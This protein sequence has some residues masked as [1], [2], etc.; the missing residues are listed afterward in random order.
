MRKKT[1]KVDIIIIAV[2]ILL[3]A[4][5]ILLALLP[6]STQ[7]GNGDTTVYGEVTLSDFN[8]KQA[9]MITGSVHEQIIGRLLPDSEISVFNNT[10][11][12][13]EALNS[14]KIDYF[15]ANKEKAQALIKERTEL[16]YIDIP[17]ETLEM[18]AMFAKTPESDK[19]RGEFD[20]FITGL[21]SDGTLDEIY[22]Y[23]QSDESGGKSVDMSGL[24]AVNGKIVLVNDTVDPP[25]SFISGGGYGG[26]EPDIIV[27]F[28]KEYGYG[29]ELIPLEPQSMIPGLTTGIY[30][31]GM[32][33]II[34]TDERKESVNFSVPYNSGDT[35]LVSLKEALH[36]QRSAQKITSIAELNDPKYKVGVGLGTSGFFTAKDVI[37]D[38]QRHL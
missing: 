18:A 28:C 7:P 2:I 14:G 3:I 33:N 11:D 5:V 36:P 15:L 23:W 29:L 34:I 17:G 8:G 12:L 24:E 10:P 9:G 26:V 1:T 31:I 21:R 19:L 16:A 13:I 38:A 22:R 4:G 30:D 35:V 27:R 32:G 20:A 25:M 37:P 6:Q